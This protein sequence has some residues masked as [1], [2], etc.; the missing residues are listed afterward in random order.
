MKTQFFIILF[1]CLLFQAC[2][3]KTDNKTAQKKTPDKITTQMAK[4]KLNVVDGVNQ[5]DQ[6]VQTDQTDQTVQADQASQASQASQA[7]DLKSWKKKVEKDLKPLPLKPRPVLTISSTAKKE[8]TTAKTVKKKE[9]M[10]ADRA[11]KTKI[12]EVTK[13]LDL[14]KENNFGKPQKVEYKE[15]N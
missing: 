4:Q 3:A 7:E 15:I 5:A 13:K 10:M 11:A 12:K 14:R 9:L 2:K 6:T 1:L 8:I